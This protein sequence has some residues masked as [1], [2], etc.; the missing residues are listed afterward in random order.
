MGLTPL[1]YLSVLMC[2]SK[3]FYDEFIGGTS[4]VNSPLNT[5]ETEK[6]VEGEKHSILEQISKISNVNGKSISRCE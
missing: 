1:L 5:D 2:L 6:L 3:K 4:E